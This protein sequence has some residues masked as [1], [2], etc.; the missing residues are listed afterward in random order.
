ME[1]LIIAAVIWGII[2][3]ITPIMVFNV[4]SSI[5]RLNKEISVLRQKIERLEGADLVVQ[6]KTPAPEVLPQII[7]APAVYES[8]EVTETELREHEEYIQ[9]K[10]H[11]SQNSNISK[12]NNSVEFKLG[13]KLPVWIG[14]ICLICAGFYLVKYSIEAG[15]F[16]PAAR[17][18]MGG[19]FGI[20]L[21]VASHILSARKHIAN[22]ERISQ[23]LAGAGLVTLYF[24]LYA[25]VNLYQLLPGPVGFVGMAVVTAGAIILSVRHGQPIAIF[26]LVG[27]LLTPALISS[28]Q[29]S[30]I[31][32]FSYLLMMSTGILFM[33]ARQGWWMLANFVVM[34]FFTWVGIWN[35]TSFV[36]SDRWAVILFPMLL[37][38]S[39]LFITRKY[40]RENSSEPHILALNSLSVIGACLSILWIESRLHLSLFDWSMMGLLSLICIGLTYFRGG[41]YEKLLWVKL[42]TDILLFFFWS[43]LASTGDTLLVTAVAAALYGALPYFIMRRVSDIRPWAGLQAISL[44]ALYL[45]SYFHLKADIVNADQIWAFA[46]VLLAGGFVHQTMEINQ[47]YSA[48]GRMRDLVMAIY[49]TAATSFLSFGLCIILPQTYIPMAFALEVLAIIWIWR[50]TGFAFL[51]K[52]GVALAVVFVLINLKYIAL[53]IQAMAASLYGDTVSN[54]DLVLGDDIV[55]SRFLLPALIMGASFYLSVKERNDG[56]LLSKLSF[57]VAA[58]LLLS[59]I[60]IF[61]RLCF[62]GSYSDVF[63]VEAG[64]IERGLITAIFALCGF[65]ILYLTKFF[66]AKFY[67]NVALVAFNIALFRIIYFDLFLHNPYFNN[68]QNVGGWPLLNGVTMVYGFGSV[69]CILAARNLSAIRENEFLRKLYK[70]TSVVLLFVFTTFTIRQWFNGAILAKGG[71]GKILTHVPL[72]T[73]SSGNMELYSY[74]IIWLL[75]AIALV[76]YGLWRDNREIRLASLGFMV[77]TIGKVFFIDAAQL[78]GLYRIFSF[79]GLG[80]CLIGLSYF[81]TKFIL[82]GKS[83]A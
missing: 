10:T 40:T 17:T 22:S 39:V 33:L 30:A 34:G 8:H 74:S 12:E 27:G 47:T 52:L 58:S 79:L 73:E 49:A 44:I 13:S 21:L 72:Y 37:L 36:D 31:I 11:K 81:Y 24:V 55:L 61:I 77:L 26:A 20:G 53:F 16:G 19:I 15:W 83:D 69:A 50:Q 54:N 59:C 75:T 18:F 45:V 1:L 63:T 41:F 51:Q 5:A 65:A 38:S 6:P 71:S 80:I 3:L 25:A 28:D 43:R 32:L 29:P 7:P 2:L 68:D 35:I 57:T 66:S 46:A 67:A 23:G 48:N 4:K 82:R 70:L 78:T 62:V 56:G 76:S 42:G 14:A 64:F 60:Y 9:S